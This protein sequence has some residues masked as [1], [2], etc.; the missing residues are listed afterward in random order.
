MRLMLGLDRGDGRTEWDGQQLQRPA[1]P[2][3]GRSGRTWTP[4]RS[5]RSGPSVRHLLMH[6][7]AS[8][9]GARRVTE[10]L[11]LVGLGSVADDSP[12]G[13]SLG[14]AQRVGLAT[15]ILAE[16]DVL[17]L[18]EPSNG[19]DPQS[20]QWLREFLRAL[21]P[22][23]PHRLRVQ[24]PAAGDAAHGGPRGGHRAG[25]GAGRPVGGRLRRP[26]ARRARS[27]CGWRTRR[28]VLSAAT[29]AGLAAVSEGPDG[30]LV[31][32][33]S[34]EQVGLLA[35]ETGQPVREL[36]ARNASLEQASIDLTR[37]AQEYTG[38]EVA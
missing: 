10:V 24:P 33:A 18:D 37:D 3:P 20:I 30:V 15:A 7:A 32:G 2:A 22:R 19:L 16:P 12:G 4:R 36:V 13:F 38:G 28:L 23:R 21:R 31:T 29:R 35:H 6:A 5:T 1:G 25:H 17:M 14:M 9:V 26:A 27:S 8:G 34:T 11:D